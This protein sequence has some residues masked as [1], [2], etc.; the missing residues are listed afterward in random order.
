MTFAQEETL[1]DLKLYVATPCYDEGVRLGYHNSVQLFSSWASQYLEVTFSYTGKESLIQRGRNTLAHRFLATDYTHFL[2]IDA[3]IAFQPHYPLELLLTGKD[4]IGGTYPKK[5]LNW[6]NIEKA[7]KAGVKAEYLR[8]CAGDFAHGWAGEGKKT[9]NRLVPVETDYL[10]TGFL[11]V[12][13]RVFEGMIQAHPDRWYDLGYP[14][15]N[16]I[17][18]FFA[19]EI[20]NHKLLSE[21]YW[22]CVEA[23]KLGFQPYLAPWIDL[24]HM[25]SFSYEG[26][27]GPSNGVFPKSWLKE[28]K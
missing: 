10:P 12:S 2:F 20:Q 11:L 28:P 4:I 8:Y 6:T 14:N 21:D 13:R 17:Y 16:K 7:V 18:E 24:A 15:L 5:N 27:L 19:V 22:F 1:K 26:Q 23:K 3:D 25:G 9:L